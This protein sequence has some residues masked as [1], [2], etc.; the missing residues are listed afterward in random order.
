VQVIPVLVL[1]AS[2]WPSADGS[3]GITSV[4]KMHAAE[5]SGEALQAPSNFYLFF[6]SHPAQHWH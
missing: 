1:N 3:S 4:A 6:S 2:D 5:N